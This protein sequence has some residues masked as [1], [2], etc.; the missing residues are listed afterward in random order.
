M[1]PARLTRRIEVPTLTLILLAIAAIWAFGALAAEMLEGDLEGFDSR[2]LLALRT[3]GQPDNPLGPAWMEELM[4]DVTALGGATVLTL[5][6]AAVTIA[7]LL[8]R[9]WRGAI[10]LVLAVIGG[11]ILGVA[12]KAGF[13]RPRPDLV[14]HAV[15]VYSH[16]FPSGH[17]MMAATTYL[18]LA[19]M[20]ARADPMRR[21]KV[22]YFVLAV[23]LTCAVGISRVYL[24]V[25]WPSDVLAG[26]TAGAGWALLCAL[27]AQWL[28]RRGGIE[29][30][31]EAPAR[32]P[33]A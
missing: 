12:A 31:A 32:S 6:T 2:I 11:R 29:P 28:E 22:F 18:T 19:L 4:R 7:F 16:A 23:V 9:E 13:S 1:Q 25:H 21:M 33:E 27:A 3:P 26:W 8:R 10:F 24:G 5:L 17:S 15:E 30:E 20:M 14:P